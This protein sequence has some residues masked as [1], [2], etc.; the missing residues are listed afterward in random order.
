[1]IKGKKTKNT[2]GFSIIELLVA[3]FIFT[4]IIMAATSTFTNTF[5]TWKKT[6]QTQADLE[7]ARTALETIGKSIRMSNQLKYSS[8]TLSMFNNSQNKCIRYN[9][10][11]GGSLVSTTC[12]PTEANIEATTYD[13]EADNETDDCG[14]DNY[15]NQVTLI[16]SDAILNFNVEETDVSSHKIGKAT[17]SI[18]VGTGAQQRRIQTTVSFRDYKEFFYTTP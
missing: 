3:V 17:M 4:V 14:G 1:M 12:T 16:S 13:C 6:R 5:S 7:K 9:S 15:G 10:D 2:R 11:V 18:L 8:D